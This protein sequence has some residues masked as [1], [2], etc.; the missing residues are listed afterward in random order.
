MSSYRK[1]PP[2]PPVVQL[3][4]QLLRSGDF[5]PGPGIKM[6]EWS[7]LVWLWSSIGVLAKA[8]V[9]GG[10][11]VEQHDGGKR[12]AFCGSDGV[13]HYSFPPGEV[14]QAAKLATPFGGF[15][16]QFPGEQTPRRGS[17]WTISGPKKLDFA[18][19]AE[20][21]D[22]NP[23]GLFLPEIEKYGCEIGTGSSLDLSPALTEKL[24][25]ILPA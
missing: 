19:I 5:I 12:I 4:L 22:T 9:E 13:P 6:V 23:P 7:G 8:G 25:A 24:K 16:I 2:F 11:A 14:I 10:L 1:R 20:L 15:K 17:L 3:W 21:I 18:E